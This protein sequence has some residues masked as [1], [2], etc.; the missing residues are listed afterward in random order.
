M[1]ELGGAR[2]SQEEPWE[3]QASQE[4]P[5]GSQGEPGGA[6]RSQPAREW[7]F[8]SGTSPPFQVHFL[9]VSDMPL[10]RKEWS[11]GTVSNLAGATVDHK[12]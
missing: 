6:R 4:E 1:G 8:K 10:F 11:E 7:F 9:P 2:G 5:W 12:P 3:S